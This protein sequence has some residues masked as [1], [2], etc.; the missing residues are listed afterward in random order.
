MTTH[1]MF[2]Q[3]MGLQ[4]ADCLHTVAASHSERQKC[5]VHVTARISWQDI[6]DLGEPLLEP[7]R[8]ANGKP[9]EGADSGQMRHSC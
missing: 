2:R 3:S 1:D 5:D 4:R 9:I 6:I 7:S 8:V